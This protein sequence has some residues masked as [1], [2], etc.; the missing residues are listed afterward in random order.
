MWSTINCSKY[1]H[2]KKLN[3]E[4]RHVKYCS[5]PSNSVPRNFDS[6]RHLNDTGVL[7]CNA[8]RCVALRC[9]TSCCVG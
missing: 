7:H 9:V 4:R 3:T 6:L 2:E 1:I 5:Q 8:L